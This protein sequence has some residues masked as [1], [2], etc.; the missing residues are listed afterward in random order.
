MKSTYHEF[1]KISAPDHWLIMAAAVLV[2]IFLREHL[3]HGHLHA[4]RVVRFFQVLSRIVVR[5][6]GKGFPS[7]NETK[8]FCLFLNIFHIA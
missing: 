2:T 4:S 5:F 1:G 6:H 7:V 3:G 8:K